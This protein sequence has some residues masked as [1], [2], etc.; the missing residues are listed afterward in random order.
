MRVVVELLGDLEKYA[1]GEG[2]KLE[3]EAKEGVTVGVLLAD[4]GVPEG[5]AWNAALNGRLAYAD[6]PVTDNDSVLTVFP[7][8]AGGAA[9]GRCDTRHR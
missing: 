2:K 3:V 9:A 6:E 8:I 4:L 1:G 5:T 7:P